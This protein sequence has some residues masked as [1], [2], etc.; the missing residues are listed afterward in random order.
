MFLFF[1][2]T[3]FLITKNYTALKKSTFLL[4]T[5]FA[6]LLL[7]N[8]ARSQRTQE[9]RCYTMEALEQYLQ[10]NPQARALAEWNKTHFA[11]ETPGQANRTQAIVTI[12]VV[13]HIVGSATRLAQVTD[14]DV[15]WQINKLNE[16]FAGSNADST[17]GAN[18]YGVRSY[19]G[20][21]QVRF[22]LAKR[23]PA[24]APST[25]ITRT[26]SAVP[27]STLCAGSNYNMLKHTSQ[28]GED[29]WDPTRFFNIWVGEVGNCLLGVAQ[30]PG[31]GSADEFGVV[32]A[33]EGFSNN[34]AYVHP[35][36]ALGRTAVHEIG[37]C[38]G[39]YHIW[40]DESGCNNSDF[41]QLTGTCAL[42]ASLAGGTTD[43]AIGDT[44]NQA[45]ATSGCPSGTITDACAA[46]S[47]GKMY[48][49][50]MDYTD[51]GCYSMFTKL[52]ADRMLWIVDNCPMVTPLKTSNGCVPVVTV[53]DD[54]RISAIITPA[55]GSST[56]CV[57]VTP[58]VTIT[59]NGSNTLTSAQINVLMDGATVAGSP[60]A[61]SGSLAPGASTNVTLSGIPL[62]PA[63]GTRNLKVHTTLP[64]GV[65]DN[66]PFNDTTTSVFT[67]TSGVALPIVQGFESATFPPTGWTE[68]PYSANTARKW[69]RSNVGSASSWSIKADFWNWASP[70]NFS[71]TTP[72][73]N[74]AGNAV[75]NIKFDLAHKQ[76]FSVNDRMR[77]QVS[78]DCGATWTTVYDKTSGTG[79]ATVAGNASSAYT[80]VA[81]D[82]RT[83]TVSLSGAILTGGPLLVR[84]LA[85]SSYGN[86]I[87]VD[88]INIDKQYERD[89]T[90][91][92]I[93]RPGSFECG[94]FDPVVTV[95]NAGAETITAFDI[96]YNAGGPN[97]TISQAVSIAPGATV[98]VTLPTITLAG[99][100]YTFTAA[101]NNPVS[102]S[103]TGD[104][105][106]SNDALT[107]S[108]L[109]RTLVSAPLVQGFESTALP[110]PGG[111]W[112]VINPNNN[113]T[114]I[115][116]A[117][118][119]GSTY[120]AFIDNYSTDLTGQLDFI[121]APAFTVSGTGGAL[122]DS[123]IITFDL[124]HQN[125]P[126]LSDTLSVR[127]SSN[128]G[129]S[130]TNI[131]FN[132][133]GPQLAGTAGSNTGA[134]TAPQLSHWQHLRV[135]T[136]APNLASG[137]LMTTFQNKQGYGNNIFL[138][139]INI[140]VLFKRDLKVVS[141][142]KPLIVEC[143]GN[144]TPQATVKN[145]GIETIT[146]FTI[147][148]SVDNGP[149]QNTNVTGINLARN[150]SMQVNLTPAVSNLATGQHSIKVYSANPVTVSG[151]GDQ[152]TNNDT[153]TKAF[154]IVGTVPA[155][156]TEGFESNSFPPAN[157]VL[158]NPNA[159]LTWSGA[160]VGK[161]SGKSAYVKNF[162][163]NAKAPLD[164]DALYSPIITYTGVDSVELSF[165]VAAAAYNYPGT[166]TIEI[167]T[168]EVLVTTDCGNSFKSVWKKTGDE[169]QT[170]NDPNYPQTVEFVPN[171]PSQ[172]RT[173]VVDLTTGYTPNGPIQLVFRNSNNS[174]NNI[175]IDNVNL[176]TRTLPAALKSQGYLVLPNPFTD[177]FNIWH[178][179]TP[180]NLRYV[181]I[182]N[183]AGQ[184]VWKQQYSG[185]AP[186]LITVD[187]RGKAAGTYIVNLGYDDRNR[188]AQVKV[189]KL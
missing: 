30:F 20:Y 112:S 97:Q 114:W 43:Q 69:L 115:Q 46:A 81:T 138:D 144:F 29:A 187:L 113:I 180:T 139:N 159:G 72:Y 130:F 77:V 166:T 153:L 82:W 98:N 52:Q 175:Y 163:A 110:F 14:A 171:G 103:G 5:V 152:Q 13:V 132:R 73:I 90:V 185:N 129:N 122:A 156:L 172:W 169:L 123:V 25:G 42:P 88:N 67:R 4:L 148:Y 86:N 58:Q 168:L 10:A 37:H 54:A 183:S 21:N 109:Q 68:Q 32:L 161:S 27:A 118:G 145:N 189:I 154:G 165:D 182:Y 39:L 121:Q 64:N 9:R 164:V 15:I 87:Y 26:L 101:T 89:L 78:N 131:L 24:N 1:N 50:Y 8:T 125:Y 160:N 157:W 28:G 127:T 31:T 92:A 137:H 18:F 94:P 136:G 151:T 51:D 61:W 107:K 176:K 85:N 33:F 134:Y 95:R 60:H 143:T 116:R 184:L 150:A 55:N 38:L 70:T 6:F 126:G 57:P 179:Q 65:A 2:Q 80:P 48:Q 106:T 140:E 120:S 108:F 141:V 11:P 173:E 35:S 66:N 47:P 79:L 96:L 135:A 186:K 142:D 174:E 44:P 111:G 12:P 178:L 34:P 59:N 177:Q 16:D 53:N 40:G 71:I 76:Y 147:S 23:T 133:G 7:S 62:S 36:F 75:V 167:D 170:I 105:N 158:A 49:N 19:N 17:N 104:Q 146:A 74:V 149:A 117:P 119:F 181:S 128:C 91:S 188:N 84:W 83:E 100:T 63:A 93:S 41:R 155:P 45:G 124:A 99:G 102:A 56:A 3:V 162:N 22:C